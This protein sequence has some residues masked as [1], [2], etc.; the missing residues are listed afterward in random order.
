MSPPFTLLSLRGLDRWVRP[1]PG[2]AALLI[3]D[4]QN[5][6]TSG[7]LRLPDA[8]AALTEIIALRARAAH[9][10]WPVVHVRHR[11]QAGGPFDLDAPRGAFIAGAEPAAGEAVVTKHFADSFADTDLRAVLDALG[12]KRLILAGFMTHNCVSSTA[13]RAVVEGY[14]VAIVASA[15]A[16]RAL[17]A[18]DGSAL[19]AQ[20]VQRA[21]LSALGDAHALILPD[22]ASV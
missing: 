4:A 1:A 9:Y 5:E 21:S 22:T 12:V 3:I 8:K 10:G 13:R 14:G 18:P 19:N 11:G 6:Y 7:P 2:E 17:P 20:A 15:T 16:T